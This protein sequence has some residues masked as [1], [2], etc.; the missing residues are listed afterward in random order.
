M[1][2]CTTLSYCLSCCVC[3][4]AC[5]LL[6]M[7]LK[8]LYSIKSRTMG[9]TLFVGIT[10]RREVESPHVRLLR[11]ADGAH[12]DR[13]ERGGKDAILD[14]VVDIHLL[15]ETDE[16]LDPCP[17]G[18]LEVWGGQGPWCHLNLSRVR[19][20]SRSGS[21]MA[22]SAELVDPRLLTFSGPLLFGEVFNE[23]QMTTFH[24]P[25]T[26]N[27]ERKAIVTDVLK[28]LLVR[29]NIEAN[30]NVAIQ[31]LRK[32]QSVNGYPKAHKVAF[33][34]H[35][36]NTLSFRFTDDRSSAYI[37]VTA[38]SNDTNDGQAAAPPIV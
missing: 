36:E 30:Y 24:N 27:K 32:K 23:T 26:A 10:E 1:A 21:A 8:A 19:R 7:R 31:V 38:G 16:A 29:Y 15:R 25:E 3:A 13:R 2:S 9:A 22:L 20:A 17:A 33:L 28:D 35:I 14:G 5:A 11:R 12:G 4:L 37:F 6:I 18:I 34:S